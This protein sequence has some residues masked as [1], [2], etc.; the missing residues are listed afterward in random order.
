MFNINDIPRNTPRDQWQRLYRVIR[1]VG[2]RGS[3]E[4][5]GRM[6]QRVALQ[7]VIADCI[8]DGQICGVTSGMDC[9]CVQYTHMTIID[10]PTP[11]AL[12]AMEE[13][14][15]YWADGPTGVGYCK[16]SER[17]EI[18]S[19]DLAMEAFENGHP[20]VVYA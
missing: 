5:A 7:Q 12:L 8:E 19:R 17:P 2:D 13:D 11:V 3:L 16:P 10:N 6:Y 4:P 18:R 14:T 9:D 15:Y 1:K 20:H